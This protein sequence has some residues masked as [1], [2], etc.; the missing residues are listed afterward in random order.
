MRKLASIQRV[1]D[2][3][4]H[5]NADKLDII[6]VLGWQLVAKRDQFAVGDLCCYVELDSV[7]PE[8]PEF[9]FLRARSFR[10]K[11]IRLRGTISQ[12][13]AFSLNEV[14]PVGGFTEGDDVTD[15]IGVKKY[16]HP[17]ELTTGGDAISGFPHF[18]PQTDET[19]IQSVPTVLERHRGQLFEM[20]EKLEGCSATYAVYD[21]EF[22]VCGRTQRLADK[23]NSL[24]WHI[25]H[26]L[27]IE[28]RLR[29]EG[30]NVAVQGEIVGPKVQGNWYELGELDFHVFNYFLPDQHRYCDGCDLASAVNNRLGLKTVPYLGQVTLNHTVDQLVQLAT[31]KSLLKPDKW[32]EGIV[33]RPVKEQRDIELGRLSFKVINAEYLLTKND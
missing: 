3:Q 32:L 28:K 2:V 15:L 7:L 31:R 6:R 21:N 12:G 16:V 10:V 1:V 26:K 13:I 33:F 11:T 14:L 18:I 22:Y 29:A 19:R 27:E 25:A 23:P 4:R 30:W 17:L 8:K 9:E 20:T 5:P 24:Y